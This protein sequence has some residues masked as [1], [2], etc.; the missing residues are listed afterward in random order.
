MSPSSP[1]AFDEQPRGS[2]LPGATE[3]IAR[4]LHDSGVD[5][6]GSLYDEALALIAAGIWIGGFWRSWRE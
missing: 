6:P 2:G 1:L 5:V 4:V 3:H